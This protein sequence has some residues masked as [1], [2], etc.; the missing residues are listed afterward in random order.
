MEAGPLNPKYRPLYARIPSGGIPN[1]PNDAVIEVTGNVYGQ[2]DAP[3]A[4]FTTF[5]T[6]AKSAGWIPSRFDPCLYTLRSSHGSSWIGILGVYVDDSAVGG[7]GPEFE[8]SINQL[9]QRFPYRK[10]RRGSGEFCGAFYQQDPQTMAMSISQESFAETLKPAY[11]PKGVSAEESLDAAQIRT[12]RGINRS[13]N[14]LANQ[15]RPD[16]LFRQALVSNVFQIQP[17]II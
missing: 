1:V 10:W 11:I 13:L 4:W 5:D 12:L 2:N 16:Q 8:A 9:K 6:E 7:M 15:S 14:W 3:C 17:F